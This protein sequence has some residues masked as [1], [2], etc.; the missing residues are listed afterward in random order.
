[1]LTEQLEFLQD[2]WNTMMRLVKE[3]E[4]DIKTDDAYKA[5]EYSRAHALKVATMALQI[6]DKFVLSQEGHQ[7][8]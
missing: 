3:H 8:G 4:I 1:M 2:A 7:I 5:I 6:A